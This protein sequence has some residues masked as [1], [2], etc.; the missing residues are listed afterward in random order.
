MDYNPL[1]KTKMYEFKEMKERKEGRKRETGREKERRA[2]LRKPCSMK[3]CAPK[4]NTK[5]FSV[6][7][8]TQYIK[9]QM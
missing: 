8:H 3:F 5:M 4:P 1:N 9:Y 2:L 6:E 7:Q